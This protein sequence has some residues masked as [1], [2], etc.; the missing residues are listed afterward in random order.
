MTPENDYERGLHNGRQDATLEN[1]RADIAE[2]R[3]AWDKKMDDVTANTTSISW[4]KRL[5]YSLYGLFVA[6]AGTFIKFFILDK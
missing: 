6:A 1:V 5:V 4:L 2:F 3:K